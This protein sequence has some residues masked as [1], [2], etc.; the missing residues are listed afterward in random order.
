M[1][2]KS[3]FNSS[4]E[5]KQ[6]KWFSRRHETSKEHLAQHEKNMIKKTK[7]HQGNKVSQ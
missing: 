2:I 7:H 1:S 6:N 5:A 3:T 4:A